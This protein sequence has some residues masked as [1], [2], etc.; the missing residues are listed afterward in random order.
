MK[1]IFLLSLTIL[2]FPAFLSAHP[3]RMD[4]N[5]C[6]V[7]KKNCDMWSVPWNQKHC[8]GKNETPAPQGLKRYSKEMAQ[9]PAEEKTPG[10]EYGMEI[11]KISAEAPVNTATEN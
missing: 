4:D 1:K 11:K 5:D 7:C 2:L 3:G 10:W 9:T 6:H 8:H